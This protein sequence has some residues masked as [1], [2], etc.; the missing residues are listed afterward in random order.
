MLVAVLALGLACWKWYPLALTSAGMFLF[1]AEAPSHADL[2]LVLGGDFWGPRV[3]KGADLGMHAFAPRVMIS[4]PF[5]QGRPEGDL[6]I[7]FLVQKGYP[8]ELFVSFAPTMRRQ[9]STKHKPSRRNSR[10]LGVRNVILVTRG[11]HSR[12]AKIVFRLFCPGVDFRSVPAHDEQFQAEQ[13]WTNPR[14][15][16]IF[17]LEWSKILGTVLVKY[18][19]YLIR[20]LAASVFT[21]RKP[22]PRTGVEPPE[23]R[24]YRP[25]VRSASRG[26]I[27]TALKS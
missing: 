5:Y 2:I 4:G 7:D 6:A 18:P 8:H 9:P 25:A 27:P 17:F 11:S 3:L 15:R 22:E 12:R 24:R 16:E 14:W 19:A 21:S 26:R 20:E 13:W 10:R 1:D 23:L